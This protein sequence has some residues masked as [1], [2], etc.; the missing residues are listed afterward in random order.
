MQPSGDCLTHAQPLFR[1]V[2][3]RLRIPI[4][5]TLGTLYDRSTVMLTGTEFLDV[6]YAELNDPRQLTP[7]TE[8]LSRLPPS[9]LS[10]F[11]NWGSCSLLCGGVECHCPYKDLYL[12]S[13]T[14]AAGL[15]NKLLR[16]EVSD[17]LEEL[18][19]Q[20]QQLSRAFH[21]A[22]DGILGCPFNW[23]VDLLRSSGRSSQDDVPACN[24]AFKGVNSFPVIHPAQSLYSAAGAYGLMAILVLEV[25]FQQVERL[26]QEA[27]I[28]EER[29]DGFYST[30]L[31]A[32][33]T[34]LAAPPS[35][36]VFDSR[37]PFRHHVSGF[38]LFI[39]E[40]YQ[41]LE[42]TSHLS[43]MN[44]LA[45]CKISTALQ[46]HDEKIPELVDPLALILADTLCHQETLNFVYDVGK[47]QQPPPVVKS[48]RQEAVFVSS[49]HSNYQGEENEDED[50][51]AAGNAMVEIQAAVFRKLGHDVDWSRIQIEQ[52]P[53]NRLE[54]RTMVLDGIDTESHRAN[55]EVW[56]VTR[57]IASFCCLRP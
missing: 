42:S 45:L 30:L 34:V 29:E 11:V 21:V 49:L 17:C 37:N 33:P 7:L 18:Q 20:I 3:F 22:I 32:I 47:L 38:D 24:E 2:T 54:S 50:K 5:K 46:L 27:M 36:L 52:L 9:D 40:R 48:L 53:E 26:M 8:V 12:R 57:M 15:L 35:A 39:A 1:P 56:P 31:E 44:V 23:Q 16:Y 25:R 41:P 28:S 13:W 10:R 6:A 19:R 14:V 43:M 4:R 55:S 51:L